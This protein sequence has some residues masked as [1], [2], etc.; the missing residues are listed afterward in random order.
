[1][2]SIEIQR[3][4]QFSGAFCLLLLCLLTLV[5]QSAVAQNLVQKIAE[6]FESVSWK[7][8]DDN[9]ATGSA[10]L[11]SD[12]APQLSGVSK[13]ALDLAPSF[14]GQGFEYFQASPVRPLVIPGVTK[15]VTLWIRNDPKYPWVMQF[16]DG[17]GRSEVGG[18]KLEWTLTSGTAPAAWNKMS[19]D[20][21]PD[22]IQ[23]ISI[24]GVFAQNWD[25][26][27]D[28]GT[29]RLGIDQLGVETDISGVDEATGVLKT[30]TAQPG[31]TVVQKAPVTPLLTLSLTATEPHNV[32]SGVK[33]QFLITAQNWHSEAAKG[34]VQWAIFDP[35]GQRVKSD[36]EKITVADHLDLPLPLD[37]T[38]Y[39][40]YRLDTTVAWADGKPVVSS[41]PY[42]V[43]PVARELTDAEKDASP[44]GLN[45]LSA[46]QPMVATFRKAGIVWFRDYGF[47][48]D[49]MVRAKGADGKYAGWPYYPK[50]VRDY[51]TNGAR[52]LANLQTAIRPPAPG[53]P[54]GPDSNWTK[55]L[56]G[57]LIAFPSIRA[58]ELDNEY[59]LNAAHAS[60]EE[61]I[62][63]KNYGLYHKK[64]GDVAGLL[65]DGRLI[66]VENGRAGIWPERERR[67]VQSGDFAPI[68]VINSHHYAGVEPPEL[69]AINHNMGFA[70]DE[71]VM[72]FFDQL[73]AVKKAGGSDGKPRQHWL[74][75]FGWDTKAGPIVSPAEQAAY[76]ARAYMLL[77]A[78][79]TAKGFW[80]WD[81]D[82]AVANQ[83]FDGCGL[84]TFDQ[85]P[86]LSYAAYAGL[87]QILP[88]PEY[89]GTISAGA[90]TWGSC[91][92]KTA[93]LWRRSGHS[94][95]SPDRKLI[96]GRLKSST[97]SPTLYPRAPSASAWSR[98]TRSASEKAAPGSGR[99]RT[100]LKRSIW[101]PSR[102]ATLSRRVSKSKT[103]VVPASMA[104]SAFSCRPDGRT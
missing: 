60:A 85:M 55:E 22:W 95:A 96:S 7:A 43:I 103:S 57:I 45:V 65:D 26:Q 32:F 14:S 39:G 87:T 97:A 94:T 49:W 54:P 58:F 17:W 18:K 4:G 80:Y 78:A 16:K 5:G 21:P 71:T 67:M 69:N 83:F 46:R 50:I 104:A 2:K 6:P 84:F 93:S 101:C 68:E 42:A 44:Y 13:N 70:G 59:D 53:V 37:T 79:G 15:R 75:E 20:V 47:S 12:V 74:T 86:K 19:F 30:W 56:A 62:G 23:P 77:S 36:A 64:F 73:R 35:N 81:L 82:S 51:D 25:S 27:K 66:T 72:S 34:T 90:D 8:S 3:R 98:S 41:Q 99:P 76:L 89:V 92:A 9:T 38:K 24:A 48:Y 10:K 28:K 33:P 88:K 102:R 40:V 11:T 100:A 31:Q 29:G 63:W 61:A 1:M 91:S 52:V